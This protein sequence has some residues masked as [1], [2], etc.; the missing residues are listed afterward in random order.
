LTHFIGAFQC[1]YPEGQEPTNELELIKNSHNL[2]NYLIIFKI[3]FCVVTLAFAKYFINFV[4]VF[5]APFS[6]PCI[7]IGWL[8]DTTNGARNDTIYTSY[9][10]PTPPPLWGL[11]PIYLSCCAFAC[12]FS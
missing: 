8:V 12:K 7:D 3:K 5:V 2:F 4:F 6:Q 10:F 11:L 1:L 9:N